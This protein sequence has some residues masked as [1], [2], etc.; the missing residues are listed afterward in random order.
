M[1]RNFHR[2]IIQKFIIIYIDYYIVFWKNADSLDQAK[3]EFWSAVHEITSQKYN[4]QPIQGVDKLTALYR[5]SIET[6]ARDEKMPDN[7]V[8]RTELHNL[9]KN[10]DDFRCTGG[11]FSECTINSLDD[12][13]PIITRK[14]QTLA[15]YGFTKNELESFVKNNRLSGIDRIVPVGRTT[16][17]SLTWD[18]YNLIEVMSRIVDVI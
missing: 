17:F 7:Y 15:Y 6:G 3:D 14:Y 10:I 5:E 9:P 16:D 1:K 12:I 8:V 13:V 18:G 4:L 2:I 11:F